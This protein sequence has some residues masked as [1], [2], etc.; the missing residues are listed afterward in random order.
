LLV[1]ARALVGASVED[2]AQES[3]LVAY[4]KW[5]EVAAMASPVGW[6]AGCVSTT[7]YRR[8]GAAVSS[9][10]IYRNDTTTNAGVSFLDDVVPARGGASTSRPAS[11]R[12]G[13]RPVPTS[14]LVHHHDAGSQYTSIRF[15]EHLALEEIAPSIGTVGDAYDNALMESIIGLYKTECIRPGPFH[16]GPLRTI[17]DVEY[18]TMAWVDWWNNRRLHSTLGMLTPDE[19]EQAHYAALTREPQPA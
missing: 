10:D 11:W 3:M 7:L 9:T 2:V 4:R 14:M 15:T 5:A 12:T 13:S 16:E 1:F 6:V 17:A 19:H 8:C 18:A